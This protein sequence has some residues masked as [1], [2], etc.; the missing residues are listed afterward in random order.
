VNVGISTAERD[1]K[2]VAHLEGAAFTGPD[3]KRLAPERK[4]Y[5]VTFFQ[6]EGCGDDDPI[7]FY[8]TDDETAKGFAEAKWIGP[9]QLTER[10]T[11]WRAIVGNP[12]NG[13]AR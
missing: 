13:G 12:L 4:C 1:G 7:V 2:I 9:F 5:V 11:S 10:I 8:A 3:L 6:Q